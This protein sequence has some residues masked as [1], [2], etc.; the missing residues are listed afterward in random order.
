MRP[1]LALLEKQHCDR[2]SRPAAPVDTAPV[3]SCRCTVATRGAISADV[4]ERRGR[5]QLADELE[6]DELVAE[7]ELISAVKRS[8][9]LPLS[10]Q[11]RPANTAE[12]PA[13]A[14]ASA[15]LRER[16]DRRERGDGRDHRG[17]HHDL[18]ASAKSRFRGRRRENEASGCPYGRRSPP[19]PDAEYPVFRASDL[20]DGDR[21][22]RAQREA[23]KRNVGLQRRGAW[24]LACHSR[25][26]S[27]TP[28]TSCTR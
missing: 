11:P 25:R 28:R 13:T 24:R 5:E 20:V 16:R 1:V 12:A 23:G 21:A 8:W 10:H 7:L 17:D 2:R 6:I 14:A 3:L 27:T 9:L 15:A 4:N 22:H 19:D 18:A 26:I